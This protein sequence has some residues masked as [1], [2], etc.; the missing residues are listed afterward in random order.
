[1]TAPLALTA[2]FVVAAMA[3]ALRRR[4]GAWASWVFL[5]ALAFALLRFGTGQVWWNPPVFLAELGEDIGA[6]F[7]VV[8]MATLLTEFG[9]T[10]PSFPV[11]V[12]LAGLLALA[13]QWA[14]ARWT[15][16]IFSDIFAAIIGIWLL[17]L[18]L[19]AFRGVVRKYTRTAD[20]GGSKA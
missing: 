5:L 18:I 11:Q 16:I 10:R 7:A 2:P 13:V 19:R 3:V 6:A 14:N 9:R 17:T 1:M 8:T 12:V 20:P 4:V 15:G